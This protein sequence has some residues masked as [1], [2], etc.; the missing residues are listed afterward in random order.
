M[1]LVLAVIVVLGYPRVGAWYVET[2]VVPRLARRLGQPVRVGRIEV[3]WGRA[4]LHGVVIGDHAP[5]QIG[6][7]EVE[8]GAVRALLGRLHLERVRLADVSGSLALAQLERWRDGRTRAGGAGTS[9]GGADWDLRIDRVEVQLRGLDRHGLA[10]SIEA[11]TGTARHPRANGVRVA[12]HGHLLEVD[13]LALDRE[14]GVARLAAHGRYHGVGAPQR[15]RIDGALTGDEGQ[16]EVRTHHAGLDHSLGVSWHGRVGR[17]VGEIAAEGLVVHAA[18]VDPA[19]AREVEAVLGLDARFDLPA[20]RVDLARAELT[21][22]GLVLRA[23]GAIELPGAPGPDRRPRRAGW[24]RGRVEV[25]RVACQVALAA[26][27]AAWTP[28]LRGYQLAGQLEVTVDAEL[29]LADLDRAVLTGRG[30]LDGCSVVAEPSPELRRFARSFE[31]QATVGVGPRPRFVVG[32]SNLAFVPLAQLPPYVA[33]SLVE[34]EDPGFAT[35]RGFEPS[36]VRAAVL[37]NLR[38]GGFQLGASS[39]TMQLVKNLVLGDA[40]TLARKAQELVLAW[41]LEQVLSKDRILELY[42]NVIEFA[43]GVYGVGPAARHYFGKDAALLTAREAAFFSAIVPRPWLGERARCAGRLD[44]L[45]QDRVKRA[46][47]LLVSDGHIIADEW[48]AATA[49][50]LLFVDDRGCARPAAR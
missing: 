39:I 28:A 46:L 7:I 25:P 10:V 14:G 23:A 40:R 45:T 5:L 21:S 1:V 11:V 15:W 49:E 38:H 6:R 35:H 48:R 22:R 19:P 17:L 44:A 42:L 32:P 9:D 16:A 34:T 27:P 26:M 30:G 29:D 50:R 3:G 12:G 43:P 2:R 24:L 13:A 8:V 33:R 31:H 41:R 36:A 18:A 4:T 20:R 47:T 37:T